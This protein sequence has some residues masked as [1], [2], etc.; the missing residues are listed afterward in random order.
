MDQ[1]GRLVERVSEAWPDS[2]LAP[3]A[4]PP[5]STRAKPAPAA[6]G[7][8][9]ALQPATPQSRTLLEAVQDTSTKTSV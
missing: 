6:A 7:G 1:A 5:A 2:S 3:G 4:S 8:L 9:Q